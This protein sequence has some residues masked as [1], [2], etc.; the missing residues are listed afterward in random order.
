M[1]SVSFSIILLM[2]D[3]FRS[4]LLLFRQCL[5]PLHRF[6]YRLCND[7]SAYAECTKGFCFCEFHSQLIGHDLGGCRLLSGK[8][9]KPKANHSSKPRFQLALKLPPSCQALCI[10]V[11]RNLSLLY[12]ATSVL[13]SVRKIPSPTSD[14]NTR[15]E[16]PGA[17]LLSHNEFFDN[18]HITNHLS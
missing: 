11:R 18:F 12:R 9:G 4:H 6:V 17:Q 15:Y 3:L 8:N 7:T 2:W 5:L 16:N 10:R 13:S 1:V 14:R